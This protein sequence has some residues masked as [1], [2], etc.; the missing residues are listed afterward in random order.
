M[1]STTT[2]PSDKGL[3]D[4]SLSLPKA[5]ITKMIKESL[6]NDIKCANDTRDLILECCVQFIH[7]ISS[8]AN[9]V[10]SQENK[11]TIAA[12]H[13]MKALT[14]LGFGRYTRDVEEVYDKHKVSKTEKPRHPKTLESLGIPQEELLR[15]QQALFARARNALSASQE[16]QGQNQTQQIPK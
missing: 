14:N 11:K 15:E 7:M 2:V 13:I 4:D 12:E 6:P 16:L 1:S 10:C 5:T 3:N 8:E 9:E